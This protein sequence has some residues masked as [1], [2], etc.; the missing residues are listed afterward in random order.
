MNNDKKIYVALGPNVFVKEIQKENKVGDFYIPDS[1]D[2]DFTYGEVISCSK[3]GYFDKGS[4]IPSNVAIGDKVMF[5]KVSGTKVTINNEK[6]IRVYMA[7]IVAKEVDGYII[8][9]DHKNT[10]KQVL[11]G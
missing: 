6:L 9:E 7:D 8:E 2:V 11:N 10:E 5:P 1:L 3:D 4:F